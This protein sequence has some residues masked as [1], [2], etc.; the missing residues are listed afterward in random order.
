MLPEKKL[1]VILHYFNKD[2]HEFK[3]IEGILYTKVTQEGEMSARCGA[4][5][6]D[7]HNASLALEPTELTEQ[8]PSHEVDIMY[9]TEESE[10]MCESPLTYWSHK[11]SRFPLLVWMAQRYLTILA[12]SAPIK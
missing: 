7:L 8:L 11:E 1:P 12:T 4:R 9:I 2:Q 3:C 10:N 6:N 5:T